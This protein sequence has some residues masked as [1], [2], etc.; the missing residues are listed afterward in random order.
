M[1]FPEGDTPCGPFVGDKNFP[2]FIPGQGFF[3]RPGN[4]IDNGLFELG[5]AEQM[6]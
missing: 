2:I 4:R 5:L 3:G 1:L 6:Q